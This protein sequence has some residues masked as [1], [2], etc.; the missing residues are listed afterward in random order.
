M[1]TIQGELWNPGINLRWSWS[2]TNGL[3][4]ITSEERKVQELYW[5]PT[6]PH[7]SRSSWAP[8]SSCSVRKSFLCWERKKKSEQAAS[9]AFQG[10]TSKLNFGFSLL[11]V[12]RLR[13]LK[14]RQQKQEV[15]VVTRWQEGVPVTVTC[16]A[17]KSIVS[18]TKVTTNTLQFPTAYN[19]QFAPLLIYSSEILPA[20]PT[21]HPS[22]RVQ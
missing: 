18:A 9:P 6:F 13:C 5:V 20:H 10:S 1:T 3:R 4:T 14:T 2:R 11:R 22:L 19:L 21:P 17:D 16:F 8:R 15:L 7:S 12:V